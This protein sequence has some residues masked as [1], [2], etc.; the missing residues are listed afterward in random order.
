MNGYNGNTY[1]RKPIDRILADLE[2]SSLQESAPSQTIQLHPLPSLDEPESVTSRK[3]KK[4]K[5]K[6]KKRKEKEQALEETS[7]DNYGYD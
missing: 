1:P 5:K 4:K 7:A 3:E 6:Q 2:E